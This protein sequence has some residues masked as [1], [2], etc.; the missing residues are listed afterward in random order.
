[1]NKISK[2]LIGLCLILL[3]AQALAKTKSTT[4]IN[5][6]I[7]H[8]TETG[9]AMEVVGGILIRKMALRIATAHCRKYNK[10]HVLRAKLDSNTYV[11]SCD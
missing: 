10:I 7:H 11:Y 9:I 6:L 5:I 2:I 8:Q 3:S 4:N 1:M